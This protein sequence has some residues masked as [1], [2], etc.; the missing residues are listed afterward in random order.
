M[1]A[2]AVDGQLIGDIAPAIRKGF[3]LVAFEES[4][5]HDCAAQWIG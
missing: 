1:L 3:I 2:I 5:F 4:S